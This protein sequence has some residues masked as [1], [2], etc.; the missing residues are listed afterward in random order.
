MLRIVTLIGVAGL[1]PQ[2]TDAA[3]WESVAQTEARYGRP[4]QK[5]PGDAPGEEQLRYRYKGC[6]ILVTFVHG[7]SDDEKYVH[8]DGRP[9]SEGEIQAFLKMTSRGKPWQRRTDPP[10]WILGG[11]GMES[12]KAVAVYYP[13]IRG[14]GVGELGICSFTRAKKVMEIK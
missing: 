5:F 10:V 2:L 3:L 13:N 7:R 11:S 4:F 1:L 9:F 6:F 8:I 14:S 12:W